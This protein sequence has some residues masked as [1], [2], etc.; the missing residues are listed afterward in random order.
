M[1]HDINKFLFGGSHYDIG[2]MPVRGPY[3]DLLFVFK[4]F[5]A[6][7]I[8]IVLIVSKWRVYTKA[9]KP[10]W[11]SVVP[12][13]NIVVLMEL[14]GRPIRW[15]VFYLLGVVFFF[16]LPLFIVPPL[17]W[18]LI[19]FLY[20]ILSLDIA[21]SFGKGIIFAIVYLILFPFVGYPILAFGKS[22]Y[23]GP[24]AKK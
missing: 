6:T 10:G 20:I 5:L 16:V 17:G 2:I 22:K 4:V 7:V 23:I 14:I 13:Y 8:A 11:T 19:T 18:I 9:G 24:A 1:W 21:R 3:D 12:I 15:V